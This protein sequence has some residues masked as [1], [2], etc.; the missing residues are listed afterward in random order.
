MRIY[1]FLG[2]VAKLYGA[3]VVAAVGVLGVLGLAIAADAWVVNRSGPKAG[4]GIHLR[5]YVLPLGGA[6]VAAIILWRRVIPAGHDF[7]LTVRPGAPGSPLRSA[8]RVVGWLAAAAAIFLA[9]S[10]VQRA[11]FGFFL[12]S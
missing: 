11:T 5:H 8:V 3:L 12:P 1:L 6:F 2:R 9:A 4:D 7:C 10:L